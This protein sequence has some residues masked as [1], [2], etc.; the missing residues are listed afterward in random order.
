MKRLISTVTRALN[1]HG[2]TLT[3]GLET[4]TNACGDGKG[5]NG[6]FAGADRN[7]KNV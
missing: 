1:P 4:D 7:R 3:S 2:N 5:F 6:V